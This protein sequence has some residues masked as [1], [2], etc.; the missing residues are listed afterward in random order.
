MINEKIEFLNIIFKEKDIEQSE[1]L[2]Y[3]YKVFLGIRN[4]EKS[5]EIKNK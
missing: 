4:I 5:I 3:L 2:I 1:T